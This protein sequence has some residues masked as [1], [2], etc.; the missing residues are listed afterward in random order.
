MKLNDWMSRGAA[1]SVAVLL[2]VVVVSG[3]LSHLRVGISVSPSCDAHSSEARMTVI[4]SIVTF[5]VRDSTASPSTIKPLDAD[6][7]ASPTPR[8]DVPVSPPAWPSEDE[9]VPVASQPAPTVGRWISLRGAYSRASAMLVVCLSGS[10]RTLQIAAKIQNKPS[11][12][13]LARLGSSPSTSVADVLRVSM[14]K[15]W[16]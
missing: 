12:S 8:I 2:H 15:L 10:V 13:R 3:F 6:S 9:A 11:E 5:G 1:L 16:Y 14:E 7:L 4:A